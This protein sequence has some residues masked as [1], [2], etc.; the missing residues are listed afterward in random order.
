MRVR[1]S[2]R[3][4]IQNNGEFKNQYMKRSR[5]I[6]HEPYVEAKK[7]SIIENRAYAKELISV[8]LKAKDPDEIDMPISLH[9]DAKKGD[10]WHWD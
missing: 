3:P 2:P 9:K 5:H 10:V 4:E 1:I 8:Y 6:R 7:W